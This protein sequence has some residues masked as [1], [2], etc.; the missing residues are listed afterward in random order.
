M[1]KLLLIGT[2]F[3]SLII[4]DATYAEVTPISWQDWNI[5]ITDFKLTETVNME[6]MFEKNPVAEDGNI[7]IELTIKIKIT[8]KKAIVSDRAIC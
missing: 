2:A 1:N 5:V 8:A 7:F 3:A 6:N 4:V